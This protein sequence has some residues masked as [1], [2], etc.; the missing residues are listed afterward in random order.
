[1]REKTKKGRFSLK[2]VDAINYLRT[3]NNH[4]FSNILILRISTFLFLWNIDS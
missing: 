4:V 3:Q 1:M 2:M